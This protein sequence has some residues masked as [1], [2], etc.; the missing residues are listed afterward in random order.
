LSCEESSESTPSCHCCH[1]SP[2]GGAVTHPALAATL[3][4]WEHRI[5]LTNT[6]TKPCDGSPA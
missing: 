3:W 1:P 5:L 6:S 2:I 4:L